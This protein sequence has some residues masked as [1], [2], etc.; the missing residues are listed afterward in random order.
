M[1]TP[2]QVQNHSYIPSM[3][4]R[5]GGVN[6]VFKEGEKLKNLQFFVSIIEFRVFVCR[7]RARLVLIGRKE[8]QLFGPR[9]LIKQGASHST[10]LRERDDLALWK[11]TQE[12]KRRDVPRGVLCRRE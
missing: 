11:V 5:F 6:F 8:V 2:W 4:M 1:K 7:K 9:P 12:F 10:N 3:S